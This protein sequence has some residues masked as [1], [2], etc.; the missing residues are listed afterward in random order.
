MFHAPVPVD[1]EASRDAL[2]DEAAESIGFDLGNDRLREAHLH[3]GQVQARAL[4]APFFA[5]AA[6]AS[7]LLVAWAMYDSVD[8][9]L[10]IG[11]AATVVFANF[12]SG[13]PAVRPPWGSSRTARPRANGRG[14]R[15]GWAGALWSSLPTLAF[16][17]QPP[18]ASW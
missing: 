5:V 14:R 4:F 12:A 7:A 6:I 2:Q 10:V 16:A 17:T 11:W 9:R 1:P 3:N 15:G 13:S 8:R 18:Q